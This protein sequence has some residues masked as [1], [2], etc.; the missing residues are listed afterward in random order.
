MPYS[1]VI[2]RPGG[3]YGDALGFVVTPYWCWPT[4][5]IP[6]PA[7]DSAHFRNDRE[8]L[9]FSG[10]G[11]GR[12]WLGAPSLNMGALASG[13]GM[14]KI[15]NTPT[16]E[17]TLVIWGRVPRDQSSVT[18]DRFI[19]SYNQAYT[20]SLYHDSSAVLGFKVRI[21]GVDYSLVYDN[22]GAS[23]INKPFA[24]VNTWVSGGKLTSRLYYDG[25]LK[26]TAQSASTITGTLATGGNR[27][28]MMQASYNGD[29]V[30]FSNVTSTSLYGAAMWTRTFTDDEVTRMGLNPAGFFRRNFA[31]QA[32][33][34]K[35]FVP[36]FSVRLLEGGTERA[37][38]RVPLSK[39]STT[40]RRVSFD[41]TSA[42]RNAITSWS[43]LQL[44]IGAPSKG[45]LS[46]QRTFLELPLG[47][48]NV[49]IPFSKV[50]WYNAGT[51]TYVDETVD[52][53]SLATG[54]VSGPYRS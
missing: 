36:G 35:R 17:I 27:P 4:L 26:K 15:L 9:A 6:L 53:A 22:S 11:T 21:S 40:V 48:G 5:A 41:L 31:Q 8:G 10:T 49:D 20:C 50:W 30:V 12:W 14:A 2:Q 29:T 44:E 7:G 54:D 45:T 37:K 1:P 23:L 16:T 13:G 39:L 51:G 34:R 42:E 3:T 43:A 28:M 19:D 46:L 33:R 24:V 52:A 32:N 38:R 47:G 18:I 25:A